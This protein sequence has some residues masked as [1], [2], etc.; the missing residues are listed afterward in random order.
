MSGGS[1]LVYCR[2]SIVMVVSW[3]RVIQDVVLSGAILGPLY[4]STE[5]GDEQEDLPYSLGGSPIVRRI[6]PCRGVVNVMVLSWCFHGH[7]NFQELSPT[8]PVST[9]TLV[10]NELGHALHLSLG[11]GGSPLLGLGRSVIQETL[12]VWE[13]LLFLSHRRFSSSR[14]ISA[15]HGER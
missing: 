1:P 5:D 14:R 9:A 7:G 3:C 12:L 13:G 6:S 8:S 15:T 10:P 2:M 11:S 4:D